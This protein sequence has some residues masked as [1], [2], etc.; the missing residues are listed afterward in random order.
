M[1]S[2]VTLIVLGSIVLNSVQA[3]IDGP[4]DGEYSKP[5]N[6]CFASISGWDCEPPLEEGFSIKKRNKLSYYI[7]VKTRGVN[8]HFCEYSGIARRSGNLLISGKRDY[9]A[10]TISFGGN[11]ADLTSEGEGCR[12]FC[13]ARASLDARELKRKVKQR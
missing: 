5:S 4:R 13:G 9:C 6:N 1:G 2:L 11:G 7:Y 3:P 8:G 12:D 10:V